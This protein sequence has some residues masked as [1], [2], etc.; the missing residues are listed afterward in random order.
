MKRIDYYIATSLDGYICGPDEDISG[1]NLQQESAGVQ[2]YLNDLHNYDTVIMGRKTYEFGYKYGL[3]PG[4]L[5]YPHMQ[6]YI[7]SNNLKLENHNERLHICELNLDIIKELKKEA[8]T[9]IYLCGGGEFSAWLLEAKLIDRII[10]K[11]NPFIQGEGS[12]LF[13]SSSKIYELSLIDNEVYDGGL[14]INTYKVKYI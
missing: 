11:L 2:K 9:D 14:M 6:H 7:F 10:V 4:D 5:A 12:K 8:G 3:K 13:S 1:F